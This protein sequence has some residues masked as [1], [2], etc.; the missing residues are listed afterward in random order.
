MRFLFVCIGNSC[1]SQIA[2]AIAKDLGYDAVSAGTEPAD[3]VHKNALSALFYKGISNSKLYPKTLK[4]VD[5]K[6][7]IVVSMGCGVECP[8]I[9]ID[10]DFGLEDPKDKDFYYFLDLV[11]IIKAKIQEIIESKKIEKNNNNI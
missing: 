1:R 10:Y 5:T 6:D 2:E 11:E 8:N 9:K 3:T 4:D 7:R